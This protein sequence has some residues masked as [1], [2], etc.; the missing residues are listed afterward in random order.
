MIVILQGDSGAFC[1]Y[2]KV[3]HT[4]ASNTENV[5]QGFTSEK[6]Y[7]GILETWRHL[8]SGEI[9]YTYLAC[10]GQC[11]V[12]MVE[13]TLCFF[14]ILHQKLC[15][16]D[17]ALKILYHMVSNQ[18]STWTVSNHQARLLWRSEVATNKCC[19]FPFLHSSG[20]AAILGF[21]APLE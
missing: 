3:N 8:E 1:Y 19:V 16:L 20:A 9:A 17:W 7:K 10:A 5:N 6:D 21:L 12:L 14:A 13:G 4:E 2:C 18:T 11:H 15:S